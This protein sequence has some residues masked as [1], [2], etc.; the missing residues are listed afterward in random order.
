L[1]PYDHQPPLIFYR[2]AEEKLF[3]GAE[4]ELEMN[5]AESDQHVAEHA[6]DVISYPG[7]KSFMFAKRDGSLTRG[8][9]FVSQPFSW[10]WFMQEQERFKDIFQR[11]REQDFEA[12]RTCGLHIHVSRQPHTSLEE[13]RLLQLVYENTNQ[14]IAASRRVNT[15]YCKFSTEDV[16]FKRRVQVARDRGF[17]N[18]RYIALNPSRHDTLEWRLW[19]GTGQFA[20]FASALAMTAG[21]HAFARSGATGVKPKWD[22]FREFVTNHS[23]FGPLAVSRFV[24]E[25]A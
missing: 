18:D 4:I 5:D 23:E 1:L 24:A 15:N 14:W 6:A 21:A 13:F 20:K 3:F 9:E 7:C 16:S 25:S 12:K 8:A 2:K 11:M 22:K 17:F 19:S 10:E